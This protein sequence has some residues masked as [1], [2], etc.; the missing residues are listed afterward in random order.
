MSSFATLVLEGIWGP[1]W[2]CQPLFKPPGQSWP[3]LLG[4]SEG[5]SA[6]LR[7]PLGKVLW[8]D[9][10]LVPV[11]SCSNSFATSKY[12]GWVPALV[13]GHIRGLSLQ[14][15][16]LRLCSARTGGAGHGVCPSP[17]EGL[18]DPGASWEEGKQGELA[19]LCLHPS[20]PGHR[21]AGHCQLH[22]WAGSADQPRGDPGRCGSL[23]GSGCSG[24]WGQRAAPVSRVSAG[25]GWA[26]ACWVLSTMSG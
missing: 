25:S 24:G 9:R 15:C 26:L 16:H 5:S 8:G 17:T 21:E 23:Q 6:T 20:R 1:H 3:G 12:H 13:W 19:P 22:T 18:W 4:S 7:D 10:P 11:K 2:L 14:L